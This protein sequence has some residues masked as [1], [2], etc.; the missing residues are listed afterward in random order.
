MGISV[1]L[2]GLRF[3][4]LTVLSFC[5]KGNNYHT[6]W[7]CKCDCG[8]N[9]VV[10]GRHLRSGGTKSCGCYRNERIKKTNSTHGLRQNRIYSIWRNMLNRCKLKT[11]KAYT[12]YGARGIKVC[13]DWLKFEGFYNW[14]INN[15]YNEKLTIERINNNGNYEPNNCKWATMEEQGNNKRNNK[16]IDINGIKKTFAK[17]CKE[18]NIK[19]YVVR[20]RLK[21]GWA[22]IE[23]F[24][25]PVRK[26]ARG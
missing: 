26:K 6:F 18:Y 14:A 1:N 19:E 13:E 2:T 24:S 21:Y 25:I 23:A 20:N 16:I 5:K 11:N 9:V 7:N 8:N 15:G 17:W 3:G 10:D 22:T 4:R 12:D